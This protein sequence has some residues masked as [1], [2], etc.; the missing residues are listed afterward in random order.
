MGTIARFDKNAASAVTQFPIES[1]QRQEL[2][3]TER[4]LIHRIAIPVGGFIPPEC[5]LYARKKIIV[6]EGCAAINQPT[7]MTRLLEEECLNIPAGTFHRI[8]N[9]GKIPAIALKSGFRPKCDRFKQRVTCTFSS[10]VSAR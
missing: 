5:H 7:G 8:E 6:L 1:V 3:R 4:I 2:M 9:G 10:F